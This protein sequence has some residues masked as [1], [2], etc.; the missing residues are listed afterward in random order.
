L[1]EALYGWGETEGPECVKLAAMPPGSLTPP[2]PTRIVIADD[3]P[4][5]VEMLQRLLGEHDQFDVVGTAANG[6]EAVCLAE[7]LK[8]ALVLMDITMPILDGVNAMR[9]IRNLPAP[10]AVILIT[11]ETGEVSAHMAYDGGAAAYFRKTEDL[12]L[13]IGGILAVTELGASPA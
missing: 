12:P 13:L 5:F 4:L 7:E 3:D 2:A 8:P 6:A 11:G 9:E 10:P 1:P